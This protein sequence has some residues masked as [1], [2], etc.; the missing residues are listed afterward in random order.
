M[1]NT[2]ADSHKADYT[3]SS[4]NL[5]ED[6]LTSMENMSK[7]TL[8]SLAISHGVNIMARLSSDNLKNIL[9]DH[10]CSGCCSDSTFNGCIQV[11]L[12]LDNTVLSEYKCQVEN[13]SLNI[14]ILTYLQ[15]KIKL[16]PLC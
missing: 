12:T 4:V 6:I 8:I 7:P 14:L 11:I 2:Y 10:L 1:Q 3:S 9:S 13:N 15:Q 16:Q 5:I